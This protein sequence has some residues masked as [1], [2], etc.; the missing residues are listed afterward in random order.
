MHLEVEPP[1]EISSASS[2]TNLNLASKTEW[3]KSWF[4]AKPSADPL[5]AAFDGE[6]DVCME[7]ETVTEEQKGGKNI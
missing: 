6:E 4:S 2:L 7:T 3:L 1:T 5:D